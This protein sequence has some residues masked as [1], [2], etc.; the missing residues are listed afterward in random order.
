MAD[1]VKV[2]SGTN[3]KDDFGDVRSAER[4]LAENGYSVGHG[5]RGCPRGILIG[6]FDIQKWRNLSKRDIADLDGQ[7]TG[8]RGGP[9][10]VR[11]WRNAPTSVERSCDNCGIR[12]TLCDACEVTCSSTS[13][14]AW[15]PTSQTAQDDCDPKDCPDCPING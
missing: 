11:L 13:L 9:V 4:W 3:P 2:F 10:E 14:I 5:Q 6:D 8:G 7:M 12:D 15:Q 1:F